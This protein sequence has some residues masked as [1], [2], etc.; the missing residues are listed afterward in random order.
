M[1]PEVGLHDPGEDLDQRR[2]SRAV[3]AE[4]AD[5]LALVDVQVDAAERVDTA[6]RLGDVAQFDEPFRHGFAP[7][8]S[9][10]IAA[11]LACAGGGVSIDVASADLR[12]ASFAT[13][14]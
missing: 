4:Q 7:T 6:E 1:S 8:A 2:L 12:V 10:P 5:D 9:G 3:V 11:G 13:A 14:L